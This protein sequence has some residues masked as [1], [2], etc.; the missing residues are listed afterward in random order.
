MTIKF[1]KGYRN[2]YKFPI[3]FYIKRIEI[4]PYGRNAYQKGIRTINF[5]FMHIV[6]SL[7]IKFK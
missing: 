2:R 1:N 6:Y 5:R 7:F 4:P 3:G